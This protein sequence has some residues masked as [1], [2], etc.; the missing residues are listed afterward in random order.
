[1]RTERIAD[2]N[3][4]DLASIE[5]FLASSRLVIQFSR[6]SAYDDKILAA[7]D[8]VCAQSSADLNV[9][10]F[11]HYGTP[12]DASVLRLLPNV[13]SLTIDCMERAES[14]SVLADLQHLE[15]LVLPDIFEPDVLSFDN[16]AR[17]KN[18]TV[19]SA[20]APLDLAPLQRFRGL[21]DLAVID[22]VK[23]LDVVGGLDLVTH[24]SLHSIKRLPLSFIDAMTGL[25]KLSLILGGRDSIDEID[26]ARIE[27]LELIRVRGFAGFAKLNAWRSLKTLEIEDQV[28]IESLSFA[29]DMTNL[30]YLRVANCKGLGQLRG[31]VT[32]PALTH[33]RLAQT[34]LDFETLCQEGLP[35]SLRQ[36][37]FY[38]FRTRQDEAI[39]AKIASMGFE[40]D[41]V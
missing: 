8:A 13:K 34:A 24:L 26:G 7:L 18:L 41:N 39:Q 40:I 27:H 14:L 29:A 35:Q 23:N 20:R 12:F 22:K 19:G 32:L 3:V 2:P 28:R 38:T 15:R 31:L 36:F 25:R 1:M 11:G 16:L 21:T 4:L 30:N 17:L 6:A 33:L 5:K 9:R 10:F 37:A